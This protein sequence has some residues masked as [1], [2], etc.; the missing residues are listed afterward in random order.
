MNAQAQFKASINAAQN[1]IV[2]TS[3]CVELLSLQPP[4]AEEQW[5]KIR[6]GIQFTVKHMTNEFRSLLDVLALVKEANF[7][8]AS[9]KQFLAR[10]ECYEEISIV[11]SFLEIDYGNPPESQAYMV[12]RFFGQRLRPIE[13]RNKT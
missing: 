3:T 2:A 11:R 4:K 9:I 6:E 8:W 12:S 1:M 7:T 5:G 10:P 13:H